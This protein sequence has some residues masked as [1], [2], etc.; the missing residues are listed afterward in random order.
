MT[1]RVC[2]ARSLR[3]PNSD[4]AG[5]AKPPVLRT[6]VTLLLAQL[7][8]QNRRVCKQPVTKASLLCP[9]DLLANFSEA[10]VRK[11]GAACSAKLSS[12]RFASKGS[13]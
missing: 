13:T 8:L 10:K 1:S 11:Q 4:L 12:Q 7:R 5:L 9:F 2:L 3:D 6:L